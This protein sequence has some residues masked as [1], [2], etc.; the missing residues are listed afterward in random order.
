MISLEDCVFCVYK[1]TTDKSQLGNLKSYC[2]TFPEGTEGIPRWIIEKGGSAIPECKPGF[3]FI[4][5]DSVKHLFNNK[6]N[7]L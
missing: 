6:D 2:E 7:S 1:T 3:R 5:E 4:P